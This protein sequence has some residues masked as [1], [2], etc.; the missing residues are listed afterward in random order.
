MN[1]KNDEK[2]ISA[3]KIE[4]TVIIYIARSNEKEERRQRIPRDRLGE[5]PKIFLAIVTE[6]RKG[7]EF[8]F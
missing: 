6:R 5:R 4:K 1:N 3:R 7:A 2:G 8:D